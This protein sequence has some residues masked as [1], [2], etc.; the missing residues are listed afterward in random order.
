MIMFSFTYIFI[1][2]FAVDDIG[3]A[4]YEIGNAINYPTLVAHS[5]RL[6]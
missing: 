6:G 3:G 4:P 5:L 2:S 1:L